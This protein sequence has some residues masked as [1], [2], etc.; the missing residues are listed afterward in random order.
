MQ[1]LK[2][3]MSR[4][5]QVIGPDDMIKAAAIQ[6]SNGDFGMLPVAE[7]DRLIGTLSDRDIVIRAVAKGKDAST[8]VRDVMSEGVIWAYE[9]D[10]VEKGARLMSEHQIRRL[11]VLDVEKKL[12]GI[13]ALGDFAV[14]SAD[15]KAAGEALSEISKAN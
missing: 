13:V 8:K 4:N 1:K 7:N 11:P 10:S 5:V 6:M 12:V 15:A 9:D 3:L 14:V 2:D